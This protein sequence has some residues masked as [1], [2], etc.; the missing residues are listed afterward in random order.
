[1]FFAAA[2]GSAAMQID[3]V[4]TKTEIDSANTVRIKR[5]CLVVVRIIAT[6][7]VL[8]GVKSGMHKPEQGET[9]IELHRA[10]FEGCGAIPAP[11]VLARAA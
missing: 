9:E 7:P 11:L 4:K 8:R 10:V 6:I 3:A 1:V 5:R 2:T